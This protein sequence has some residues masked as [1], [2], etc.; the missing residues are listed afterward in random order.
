VKPLED[1]AKEAKATA[2]AKL[3]E[4]ELVRQKV[5]DIRAKV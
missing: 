2:D 5:A 3:A 4:L 1:E